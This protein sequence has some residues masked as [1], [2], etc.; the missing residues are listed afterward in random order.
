MVPFFREYYGW[1]TQPCL[2]NSPRR[3]GTLSR[4]CIHPRT[5]VHSHIR[6][7]THPHTLIHS[8]ARPLAHN[9]RPQ[10]HSLARPQHAPTTLAHIMCSLAHMSIRTPAS[11]VCAHTRSHMACACTCVRVHMLAHACAHTCAHACAH[12]RT[13]TRTLAHAHT[14]YFR[15]RTFL[16]LDN[17]TSMGLHHRPTPT[18]TFA[19]HVTA[20]THGTPTNKQTTTLTTRETTNR[21]T[22]TETS[23]AE[24]REPSRGCSCDARKQRP[25]RSDVWG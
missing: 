20:L 11:H 8:L 10:H 3:Y 21:G 16:P 14:S 23:Q 5:P 24:S 19:V 15:A 12:M 25:R 7:L 13:S 9:T 1:S 6:P 17:R 22:G 18:P 2:I 4:V